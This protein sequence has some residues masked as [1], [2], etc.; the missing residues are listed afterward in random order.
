MKRTKQQ[1]FLR[2]TEVFNHMLAGGKVVVKDRYDGVVKESR[3]TAVYSDN[4][5]T[6]CDTVSSDYGIFD[7]TLK[8]CQN[9]IK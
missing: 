1:I 9:K 6:L 5:V 2:M 4:T 3:I 7:I 8:P